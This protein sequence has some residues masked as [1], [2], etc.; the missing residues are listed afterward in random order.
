MNSGSGS[1]GVVDASKPAILAY[2]SQA[3][4]SRARTLKQPYYGRLVQECLDLSL[5]VSLM[6]IPAFEVQE[7]LSI[8]ANRSLKQLATRFA[9]RGFPHPL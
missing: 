5:S 6:A 3:T 8:I 4:E 2:V 1:F 9:K 7:P